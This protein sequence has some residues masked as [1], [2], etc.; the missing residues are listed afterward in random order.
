[1]KSSTI[2]GLQFPLRAENTSSFRSLEA[3]TIALAGYGNVT[4]AADR[5]E[6]RK[7][8]PTKKPYSVGDYTVASKKLIKT[9]GKLGSG[10][11]RRAP[12]IEGL[13]N[14]EGV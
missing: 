14:H 11:A 3:L 1:M 5:I 8:L 13:A 6:R 7:V 9:S 10:K 4:N 12:E 2:S